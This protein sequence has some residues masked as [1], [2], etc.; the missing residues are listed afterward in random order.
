MTVI[1][2]VNIILKNN[3]NVFQLLLG[4]KDTDDTLVAATLVC[5]SELVPIL[6]AD[7]VVGGKRSKL[8]SDGRPNSKPKPLLYDKANDFTES[9]TLNELLN[10]KVMPPSDMFDHLKER[11][12]PVGGEA[13]DEEITPNRHINVSEDEWSDWENNERSLDV[14]TN[15]KIADNTLQLLVNDI[16]AD[17][18]PYTQE[19]NKR[20]PNNNLLHKAAMKAKKKIIDIDDL[21]IK[22]QK[23]D[24]NKK[25]DGIDFFADMEPVIEKPKVVDIVA[26]ENSEIGRKFNFE[27]NEDD[28]VG[29][30]EESWNE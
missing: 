7:A 21:D 19:T 17:S 29:W 16:K 20:T 25:D 8:F 1:L 22:N 11:P 15:I 24:S 30:D 6:G 3:S 26:D 13:E 9:N 4:I 18:T 5:L 23:Y 2:V 12:P 10:C 28:E 27:P 14:K